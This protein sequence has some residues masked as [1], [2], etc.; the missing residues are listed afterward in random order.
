MNPTARYDL[1]PGEWRPDP[2]HVAYGCD[3]SGLVELLEAE[4]SAAPWANGESGDGPV[5]KVEGRS[6]ACPPDAEDVAWLVGLAKPAPYGRGEETLLD[7]TVRDALQVSAEQV[8]LA[9]PSWKRLRA[10][11]LRAVAREMGLRQ[12]KLALKPLKLLVYRKG[13]HFSMHAD[14]EKTPGMVGS[15]ALIL[16]GTHAGGA[17][18][19][20]HGGEHLCFGAGASDKWRFVAW[21]ADC[22]HRLE[23]VEKGVRIAITFGVAIDPETPLTHLEAANHRFGWAIWGRTYAEWHTAWAARG[24]R[25][26]AG[27]EQYGQKLVWV[28]SHRYTEP[29]LRASLLKGRDRELARLLADEIHGEA[30]YLGWLQIREVGSAMTPEGG[31]WGDHTIVWHEPEDEEDDDPPP[32]SVREMDERFGDSSD[33]APRRI[34]HI[35]T[36]ELHLDDVARQNTWFEGLRA[37]SGEEVDHGPI[38]VLDGEIVPQGAL[39]E[40]VPDGARLYEATGNEGAS[41]ELQY[42]RAVLVLWR[43]NEATLRMLARCG[44]RLALA[45]ELSERA[46]AKGGE[47][48]GGVRDVLEL[49]QQA[50][51]TDGGGPEPRA[52]RLVLEAMAGHKA[53]WEKEQLR[54]MYVEKVARVD[55]DAEAVPTLVRWIQDTMQAGEPMDAW[56]R[57]LGPACRTWWSKEVPNGAPG[58]LRALCETS[59]TEVLAIQLL[60]G[61]RETE[62]TR[63]AVLERAEALE[64]ALERQ[65]WWRRRMARMT[66]DDA[67]TADEK[68]PAGNDQLQPD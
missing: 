8:K 68:L 36:P 48:R 27:N 45:V 37:L 18:V 58:L 6:L 29:G 62:T 34:A 33:P 12:A 9:G 39:R 35:D 30:A 25:T 5:L 44:G 61:Q 47:R 14:T 11:M 42:R 15:V 55:L 40:T 56:V 66:M 60:A 19:I 28:L 52:H 65:A 10:R 22:R 31:I 63:E 4:L 26:Q 16:P 41:M 32:E 46:R 64:V 53:E 24:V 13:G 21:Y 59:E 3:R 38:E 54:R 43:R 50:R 51:E 7:P 17:L 2:A 67:R 23:P 57:A 49:W 1:R 20:E